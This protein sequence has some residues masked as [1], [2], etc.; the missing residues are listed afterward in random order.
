MT[1]VHNKSGDG[2]IQI[3][4]DIVACAKRII[5]MESTCIEWGASAERSFELAALEIDKLL[6]QRAMLRTDWFNSIA[7]SLVGCT[8][9]S[10]QARQ[11]HELV[12]QGTAPEEKKP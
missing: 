1:W 5:S 2:V 8:F 7:R 9:T 3:D 6:G 11:L 10:E 4:A 12:N